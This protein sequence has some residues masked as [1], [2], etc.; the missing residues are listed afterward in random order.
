MSSEQIKLHIEQAFADKP[1]GSFMTIL[2]I[3]RAVTSIYPGEGRP[4]RSSISRALF[5]NSGSAGISGVVG[6]LSPD[7]GAKGGRKS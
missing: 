7:T 3:T 5:P 1:S 6:D 4:S 2:E